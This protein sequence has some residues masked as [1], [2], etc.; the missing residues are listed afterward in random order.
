MRGKGALL[1]FTGVYVFVFNSRVVSLSTDGI[2]P[3]V[4]CRIAPIEI[5]HA[6]RL[7]AL[8]FFHSLVW[9]VFNCYVQQAE[10]RGV[11]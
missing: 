7:L 2:L 10:N 6:C 11:C 1:V 3:F 5:R 9:V 4:Y 8:P